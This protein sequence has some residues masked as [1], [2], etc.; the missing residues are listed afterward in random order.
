MLIQIQSIKWSQ[1][2][3]LG[4]FRLLALCTTK[5]TKYC[6]IVLILSQLDQLS[7]IK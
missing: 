1:I 7:T 3:V 4:R 6:H 5:L 2:A